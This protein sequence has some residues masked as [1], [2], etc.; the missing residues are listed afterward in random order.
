MGMDHGDI[1]WI[2]CYLTHRLVRTTC[3]SISK[4]LISVPLVSLE[5]ALQH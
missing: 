3:H 4:G 5:A 1:F 2:G